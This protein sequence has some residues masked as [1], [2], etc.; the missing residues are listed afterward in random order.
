MQLQIHTV[1]LERKSRNTYA[2]VNLNLKN[3]LIVGN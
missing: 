1:Y 3:K 2:L